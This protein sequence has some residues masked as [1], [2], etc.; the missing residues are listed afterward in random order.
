M[1]RLRPPGPTH[2]AQ[3]D[4]DPD[5]DPP[6]TQTHDAGQVWPPRILTPGQSLGRYRIERVRGTGAMGTVYQAHDD[7]LHRR[8]AIK[9][10]HPSRAQRPGERRRIMEEARAMA[11]IS[12][13][14]VVPV[15][16]VGDH[17]GTVFVVMKLVDAADLAQWSTSL[18]SWE[19]RLR[20]ISTAGHGLAAAHA[21]GIVHRDIKPANILVTPHGTGQVTDFGLALGQAQDADERMRR[22]GTPAY[23]APE[24]HRGRPVDARADQYAFC[25]T[26]WEV[27]VGVRPFDGDGPMSLDNRKQAGPPSLDATAGIPRPVA[28]ALARGLAPDPRHRW[29]D[30]AALLTALH[31]RPRRW[32]PWAAAIAVG[33]VAVGLAAQSPDRC[34]PGQAV[35][36]AAWSSDRRAS[37]EQSLRSTGMET[38]AEHV[39]AEVDQGVARWSEAYARACRQGPRVPEMGDP[40]RRCLARVRRRFLAWFDLAEREPRRAVPALASVDRTDRCRTVDEPIGEVGDPFAHEAI[41]AALAQGWL[42]EAEGRRPEAESALRRAA[43]LARDAAQPRQLATALRRL[44]SVQ[45]QLGHPDEARVTLYDALESSQRVGSDRETAGVWVELLWVE[46]ELGR[47]EQAEQANRSAQA[48]LARFGG[49]RAIDAARMTNLAALRAAQGRRD[50]GAQLLRRVLASWSADAERPRLRDLAQARAEQGLAVFATDWGDLPQAIELLSSARA[51]LVRRLGPVNP[52]VADLDLNLA[53]MYDAVG[54]TDQSRRYTEAAHTILASRP[55]VDPS[56]AARIEVLRSYAAGADGATEQE[57]DHLTRAVELRIEAYGERDVRAAFHRSNMA[58]LWVDRGE[59]ER[60]HTVA[61]LARRTVVD[62]AVPTTRSTHVLLT[63]AEI[64]LLVDEVQMGTSDLRR[65][66]AAGDEAFEH[67]SEQHS[68]LLEQVA[69][70][71]ESV[72]EA[73]AAQQLRERLGTSVEPPATPRPSASG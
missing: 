17:E 53:G 68:A 2:A 41:E 67:G 39:L 6:S 55:P 27:L 31:P 12:H 66:I 48:A 22:V 73:G 54:D 13:P 8:V 51:R 32:W 71:Y 52:S 30:L 65:T 1:A 34:A 11:R 14:G 59:F 37:I 69:A 42:A 44:G 20:V 38:H 26:A 18:R 5:H 10:V 61:Q 33:T 7:D 24:Q 28:A 40:R 4:A 21:A 49:D 15:Y 36:D 9:V 57:L 19:E 56:A 63:A 64:A 25:V 46:R 70:L 62:L 29:P 50:E 45:D 3:T 35:L 60:G 47:H 72:G 16:D 58:R 23:M 43:Q